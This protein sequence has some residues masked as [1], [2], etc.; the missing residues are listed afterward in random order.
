MQTSA[1]SINFVV[2]KLP[3]WFVSSAMVHVPANQ[4]LPWF[5]SPRTNLSYGSCLHEP[6]PRQYPRQKIYPR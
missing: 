3:L 1:D 5:V 6:I 2:K 4:P